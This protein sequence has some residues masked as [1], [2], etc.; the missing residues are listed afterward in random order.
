MKALAIAVVLS[1]VALLF[2]TVRFA[3]SDFTDPD[4]EALKDK[5]WRPLARFV[6]GGVCVPIIMVFVG[7]FCKTLYR[8]S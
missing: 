2:F 6:F 4:Y 7:W 8:N 3:V 5:P 1:T